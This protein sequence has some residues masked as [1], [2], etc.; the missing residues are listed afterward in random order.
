MAAERQARAMGSDVRIIVTDDDNS[1]GSGH[2]PYSAD[3][4]AGR[5]LARI[6]ELERRW[7]R[8][9]ARSEICLLNASDGRPTVVSDDT[10]LLV[11]SAVTAWRRSGGYVDCTKLHAVID[12]GYDRS[13]EQ[14]PDDRTTMPMTSPRLR[15]TSPDDLHTDGNTITMPAGVGFD[16]GGIGKGLAA[17]LVV[18]EA[19]RSGAA[20]VCVD[21]G[22]DVR[23][24][25]R[26]PRGHGWTIAIDHP[27]GRIALVGLHDGAVATSTTLRRRW[28][29]A[30]HPRHHLID[31]RTERPSTSHLAFV[32]V[33]AADTLRAETMAK[34]VLL[35]GGDHPFDLLDG[36]GMEALVVDGHGGVRWS[37][38]FT[39]FTGTQELPPTI[40][41]PLPTDRSGTRPTP[42]EGVA[43]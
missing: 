34:A 42:L 28:Q 27:D 25:G 19:M 30:G 12:A 16:P 6:D 33:V 41:H 36:K 26:A 31:P 21:L 35:R 13:F 24:A 17:D 2:H 38:G 40:G 7:S 22:G 18:D 32:T 1:F 5:A 20:G 23:V 15:R 9:D 43:G 4:I 10:R 39:R 8:F 37:E 14:I 11:D 29:I 3:Q